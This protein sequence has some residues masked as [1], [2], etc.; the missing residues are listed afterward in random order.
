[1]FEGI[2]TWPDA[3]RFWEIADKHQVDILY[4]APTAI[5]SLMGC[6]LS[7]LE[8]K[9]LTSLKVLGTVGE[10][11]NEEA[12]NWY[13]QHIGHNKLPIV[14]TWWQTETGGIMISNLA[15]V[16]P[17]KSTYATYPLPGILPQLMDENG[18]VLS[19]TSASGKLGNCTTL[20]WHDSH[21]MGRSREM[22][23]NL[24]FRL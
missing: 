13:Y 18:N 22:P 6:G 15:G 1:M 11:I 3:G 10:P 21:Y 5:R 16:T 20:A 2:P 7:P 12:W 4:T 24:F 8:G 17:A 23:A 9:S 19:E 14:D